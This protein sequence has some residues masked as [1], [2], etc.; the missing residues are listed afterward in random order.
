[1]KTSRFQYEYR[2][3]ASKL[4]RKVGDVLRESPLFKNHEIY[5]EY[6]VCRVNPSYEDTSN[7]FDWVIADMFLVIECHGKQHYE[8][9]DFT[10]KSED[11]GIQAFKEGKQRDEAK[12]A[13]AI[14][15]GWTYLEIPYTEEKRISEAYILDLYQENLN[16]APVYSQDDSGT[17]DGTGQDHRRDFQ[18]RLREKRQAYLKSDE[19]QVQLERARRLRHEQYL[20]NKE[21]LKK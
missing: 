4:H 12:R 18:E 21:R 7:H 8:V 13:A 20:R 14:E 5:Q 2:R 9:T 15:A 6:P 11:G 19:H 1:M 16:T 17:S 10:G 3:S